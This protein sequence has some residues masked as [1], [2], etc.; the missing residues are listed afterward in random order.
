M[1]VWVNNLGKV[2]VLLEDIKKQQI[3]GLVC[4]CPRIN[5]KFALETTQ[6]GFWVVTF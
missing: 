2:V 4:D 6:K 5:D 3:A 1:M